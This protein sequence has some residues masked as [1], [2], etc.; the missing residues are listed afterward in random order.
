MRSLHSS[1]YG[2]LNGQVSASISPELRR[3]GVE[4]PCVV[5]D[6]SDQS[7]DYAMDGTAMG[8][9]TVSVRFDCV[10]ATY[11]AANTLAMAVADRM[12]GSWTQA[13]IAFYATAIST[14]LARIIPD[15]GQEDVSRV[16]TVSINYQTKET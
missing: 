8:T 14:S 5:Y 9:G 2:R 11:A 1:I 10:A 12:G 13:T 3:G 16:A 15:D 4:I 7:H 6:L